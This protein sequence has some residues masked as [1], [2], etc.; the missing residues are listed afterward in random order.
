MSPAEGEFRRV[1]EHTLKGSAWASDLARKTD[2]HLQWCIAEAKRS[3]NREKL[4]D[5][6]CITLLQD[7]RKDCLV[8]RFKSTDA[9]LNTWSGNSGFFECGGTSS[10]LP[11]ATMTALRI[12][13]TPNFGRPTAAGSNAHSVAEPRCDMTLLRHITNVTK[14]Y[15]AD[16]ASDEQVAGE[17]LMEPLL[18]SLSLKLCD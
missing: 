11:V 4:K 13:C 5:A 17:L 7:K 8:I 10:D 6:V 3:K 1:W 14:M 18:P 15:C 12:F 9:F 16:A 2:R